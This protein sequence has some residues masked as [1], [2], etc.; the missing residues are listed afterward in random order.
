MQF[1]HGNRL[2]QRTFL[3]RHVTQLCEFKCSCDDCDTAMGLE[4]PV[5]LRD[6]LLGCSG[7]VLMEVCDGG[8]EG[9]G[10]SGWND[11]FANHRPSGTYFTGFCEKGTWR[12]TI[13]EH[14]AVKKR[15]SYQMQITGAV[16]ES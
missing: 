2:L 5:K 7:P 10:S 12:D 15:N 9:A 14:E 16:I 4:A 6:K 1:E 8:F 11:M 13:K 3:R